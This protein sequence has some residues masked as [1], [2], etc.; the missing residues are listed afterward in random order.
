MIQAALFS[1]SVG[2][3]HIRPS[4]TLPRYLHVRLALQVVVVVVVVV[5]VLS[6][7]DVGDPR[8]PIHGEGAIFTHK[9]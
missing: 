9:L 8:R 5:V 1:L 4:R 7:V 2:N 3:P 6:N